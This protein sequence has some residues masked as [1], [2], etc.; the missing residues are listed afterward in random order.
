MAENLDVDE[1]LIEEAVRLGK[2]ESKRDAIHAALTEYV[3]RRKQAS[4]LEM[5]G[6]VD[7][8]PDYDYKKARMKKRP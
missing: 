4:I 8:Y 2:F 7:Y 1:R 5:V 3:R 6:K